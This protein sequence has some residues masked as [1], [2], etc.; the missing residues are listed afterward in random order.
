MFEI[1]NLYKSYPLKDGTE[2][3]VLKN[4]NIQIA[5]AKITAIVGPSGSGKSTLSKCLSLLEQPSSGDL[6]LD[7]IHLNQLNAEE[8][9]Q[10]RQKIGL[11]F[12]SS[13]LL[14]RR[15]AA[16]NIALPLQFL[17][18]VDHQIEERVNYLLK[19]VGLADRANHYPS[20]LSG[21]Q[22]QRVGI[23]RALA[24]Q[25]NIVIADEATSGL[26]PDST[27]S[28]LKLLT[29]LRDQ[30]GLSVVLITHEMDVVRRI[31]DEVTVLS[32]GEIQEQGS[33]IELIL[34]PASSIGQKLLPIE[35]PEQLPKDHQLLQCTY[36]SLHDTP[37]NWL[38]QLAADLGLVFDVHASVV[39]NVNNYTVGKV[40][41]SLHQDIFQQYQQQ[42]QTY[43]DQWQIQYQY[44][45]ATTSKQQQQAA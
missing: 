44:L 30:L 34:D 38:S 13:A 16:E 9:R 21:G 14:Q 2:A 45:N 8:L 26:D 3:Q 17:G 22:Q 7:G 5:K 20:Q 11:V 4:I 37:L 36:S 43:L 39:E 35:L 32:H 19:N 23:A 41:L 31:A 24:L 18:V 29:E 1:R 42:L 40:I 12:Q 33:V 15:T 25:P 10:Q 6:I 27:T 28:I